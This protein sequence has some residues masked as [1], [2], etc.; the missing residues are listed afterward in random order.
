MKA[1]A[2]HSRIGA[3]EMKETEFVLFG[4]RFWHLRAKADEA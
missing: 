1:K 2:A 3:L 4:T